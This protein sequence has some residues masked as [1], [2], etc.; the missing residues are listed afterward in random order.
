LERL[1][2][3]AAMSSFYVKP[4]DS[5]TFTKTVGETDKVVAFLASEEATYVSGAAYDV[6]G[7]LWMT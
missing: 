7:A 6:T 1:R 4:G 3:K 2:S 5:V